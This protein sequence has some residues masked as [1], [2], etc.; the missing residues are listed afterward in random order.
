MSRQVK[1]IVVGGVVLVVFVMAV[2]FS[3]TTHSVAEKATSSAYV[4]S[5]T[6]NRV[7]GLAM[8]DDVR[9]GGINVGS[10]VGQHLDGD[11]RAVVAMKIRNGI[12]LPSDSSVS[13]LTSGLF[14]T[15][16]LELE[17]GFEETYLAD[18][19]RINFTQDAVIVSDLLELIISQGRARLSKQK[20]EA[21][22]GAN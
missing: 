9:L 4:V 19:D 6:F 5:A 22:P 21:A 12:K 16:Y 7:D 14:G 8:G 11:Y 15:K 3:Y 18:G 2:V 13:I 1:E 20:E 17:P 10:V